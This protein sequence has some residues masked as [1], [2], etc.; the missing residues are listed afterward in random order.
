MTVE[1]DDAAFRAPLVLPVNR[2]NASTY[3]A[4]VFAITSLGNDGAAA[5]V[6]IKSL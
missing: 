2:L 5:F 1:T 4:D 6:P 3:L